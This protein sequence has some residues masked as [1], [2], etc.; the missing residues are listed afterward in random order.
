MF[1]W[2]LIENLLGHINQEKKNNL[3]KYL[4]LLQEE[5][6]KYNL[7]AIV[8]SDE[9]FIK[10]FFDSILFTK[11]FEVQTQ[12]ILDIGTGAGFP[13]LV[14]KILFPKTKIYLLEANN[15]KVVFLNYVIKELNLKDVFTICKRAEDYSVKH[16]EKFDIIISR[17]MAPLGILLEV[18]V[19]ALKVGGVFICLKSKNADNEI[20]SLNNE[21]QKLELSLQKTQK[22][23]IENLGERVNLFYK[24]IASTDKIYPRSYAQIKK[25]PLGH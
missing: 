14:L 16:R 25:K 20:A 6:K 9:I 4:R 22:L 5:N 11:E 1:D 2:F 10:H 8:N 24:K 12:K 3:L 19:Q 21:E 7:T 13:G 23:N 18:G 17:A 15:K